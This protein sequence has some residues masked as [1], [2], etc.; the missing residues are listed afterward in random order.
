MTMDN[1][2]SH[3]QH[4]HHNSHI[5]HPHE[6]H[7]HHHHKL[8]EHDRRILH[9]L[10]SM[11]YAHQEAPNEEEERARVLSK[12]VNLLNQKSSLG[13]NA[14]KRNSGGKLPDDED[15]DYS[16]NNNHHNSNVVKAKV[17]EKHLFRVA[18]TWNEYR[19]ES[20]LERRLITVAQLWRERQKAW[21][22]ETKDACVRRRM[23]VQV[24][25]LIVTRLPT[26]YAA[27]QHYLQTRVKLMTQQVEMLLYRE[28][29]SQAAY[30][31]DTTLCL[32]MDDLAQ[33]H[34]HDV[35]SALDTVA[36]TLQL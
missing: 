35:D 31:D 9:N 25:K 8:Q 30:M 34:H 28:A 2:T 19:D 4:Q 6:H 22:N 1:N 20:T 14:G 5:H 18:A 11:D 24:R 27:K 12:I 23:L 29:S 13:N 36:G 15:D 33:R 26:D 7:Q 16:S 17:L 32:R 21:R 10:A 3:H